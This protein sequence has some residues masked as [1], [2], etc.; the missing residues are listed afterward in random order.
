MQKPDPA[1]RTGSEPITNNVSYS[2]FLHRDGVESVSTRDQTRPN[3]RLWLN[4]PV[5]DAHGR[6][7]HFPLLTEKG[8][9]KTGGYFASQRDVFRRPIGRDTAALIDGGRLAHAW[10]NGH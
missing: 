7:R 2:A 5:I 4:R 6:V 9:E 10:G 3:A 1:P 8:P